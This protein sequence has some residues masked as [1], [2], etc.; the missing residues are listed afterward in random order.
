M[1]A[2]GFLTMSIAWAWWVRHRTGD[3]PLRRLSAALVDSLM[4]SIA[5]YLGGSLGIV[6]YPIYLQSIVG[7]T[8]RFG[9]QSLRFASTSAVVGF[10]VVILASEHWHGEPIMATALWL[11]LLILPLYYHHLL[12]RHTD[13]NS[14]L[15]RELNETVYAATHDQLTALA[16]RGYFLQRLEEIIA[17]S[18]RDGERFALLYLDLDGFKPIN[19]TLGHA[20]GDGVLVEV[21]TVLKGCARSTD[22]PV[23]MGGDEFTL[24]VREV[25]D[26]KALDTLVHRILTGIQAAG[27]RLSPASTLSASVGVSLYPEHGTDAAALLTAADNAMYRAKRC[28]NGGSYLVG[29]EHRQWGDR[30]H[31]NDACNQTIS[32]SA[33]K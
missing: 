25:A 17:G 16:N 26:Q 21:A 19:D 10:G 5:T 24:L 18:Q 7:H 11:G 6:F 27:R 30:G 28:G 20:A 33:I 23:R 22:L 2:A 13:A 8:M 3:F 14:A 4:A 12:Q 32:I 9:V 29:R 1:F 15:E 31:A